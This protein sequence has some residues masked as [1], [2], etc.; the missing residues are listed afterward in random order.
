[1]SRTK[2]IKQLNTKN[3]K[4]SRSEI[5]AIIDMFSNN[6]IKALKDGRKVELR[7]FG[8]FFVKKI[9]EN[10]SARNPKTGDLIYVP[11]KNKVRFRASK[12]LKKIINEKT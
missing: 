10:Y 2:L 4:L 11:E 7:G 9:K 6:I 12:N 8:T 5:E 1:M 3:S